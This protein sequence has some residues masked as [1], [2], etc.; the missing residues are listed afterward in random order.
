M[1]LGALVASAALAWG[2][3]TVVAP[4]PA[5]PSS[6]DAA[7][8]QVLPRHQPEVAYPRKL[9]GASSDYVMHNVHEVP[10]YDGHSHYTVLRTSDG[11][12]AWSDFDA[13]PDAERTQLAGGFYAE[14]IGDQTYWPTSVRFFDVETHEMV[15]EITRPATDHVVHIGPGWILTTRY[16][17]D[18]QQVSGYFPVVHRLDGSST[19]LR[20]VEVDRIPT[21]TPDGSRAWVQNRY[22]KTLYDIDAAEGTARLVP[23][24]DGVN[25]SGVIA[26]STRLFNLESSSGGKLKVT[27]IE[28]ATGEATSYDLVHDMSGNAPK[29]MA[30]GDGLAAYHQIDLMDGV[31]RPVDL[32][33]GVVGAPLATNLSHALPAGSGKVAMV[34]SEHPPGT[35]AIHDGAGLTPIADLPTV[36]ET[37]GKIAY[38]GEVRARW[39]D[40]T[41]WSI[42]PRSDEPTWNRTQWTTHQRVTTSGGTTLVNELDAGFDATTH[43]RMT[44]PGGGRDV[45]ASRMKLGHGGQLVVRQLPGSTTYQV[46]RVQTGEVVASVPSFD[47]VVDGSWVWTIKSGVL[48]GIDVDRP[49]LPAKTVPTGRTSA[50]L[51]DVRGRWALVTTGGFTV[52]DTRQVV[53]P[54]TFPNP[55]SQG[56]FSP[57]GLGAGFVVWSTWTYDQWNHVNGHKTTVTDLGPG[58]ESRS[59]VDP[60]FGDIPTKY[61][62][63]EA[64]SPSLAYID[65]AGQ[66]RIL[67]L[68]WLQEAPLTLPDTAPP[69]LDSTDASASLV[70]SSSPFTADFA[71]TYSDSGTEPSPASGIASYSVR[72]RLRTA[73]DGF[74]AW[75]TTTSTSAASLTRELQPGQEICAQSSATDAAGNTSAWSAPSCTQVDGAA[76]TLAPAKGSPR[77]TAPDAYGG[78]RYRYGATDDHRVASYDVQARSAGRGEPLGGWQTVLTRTTDTLVRRR[79]GAG[80]EWCFRFRARDEAGNVSTWSR[81]RCSS[82]AIQDRAFSS[83]PGSS[84]K[85]SKLALDGYYRKLDR[86]GAWLRLPDRQVGRTVALWVMAGPRQGKADVYVGGVRVGRMSLA[87]PKARRKLVVYRVPRDG[88]VKVVQRGP[89]PVGVDALAVER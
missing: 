20:D 19:E 25:W 23:R 14:K 51:V 81:A 8:V 54:W 7:D 12:A 24:P 74:A 38:D 56:A 66:P 39:G 86:A 65:R 82:L 3:L 15:G 10:T 33:A 2:S 48:T 89:R 44:W 21:L 62:V 31:L 78:V 64:G 52:V 83:S 79:A 84:R 45:E 76:P 36:S 4:A 50:G 63:D 9:V 72:S 85:Y 1:R 22:D 29:F 77:F 49:E 11:S 75:T 57:P 35:I 27:A 70:K 46:E 18:S 61:T 28:R 26:G 60:E 68:P 40:G 43:W 88:V 32:E 73:P 58:H 6:I 55:Q 13:S 87:A 67:R 80:S 42:D 71:W 47:A 37:T 5:A 59:V 69:V 30:L 34:V 16:G 17:G 41:T 53:E